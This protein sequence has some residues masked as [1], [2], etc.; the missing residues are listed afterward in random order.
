M[1][2]VTYVGNS[3]IVRRTA[4]NWRLV[5]KTISAA[6]TSFTTGASPVTLFNV[7]GDVVARVFATVQTTV[8][9]TSN[10]GTLAI[11]VT[12]NTGAF[13]AATTMDG[14]NLA[15]GTVWAGDTSPAVKS[16]AFSGTSLNG[17]PIAGGADII[18]T[19]ATNSATAG[20]LVFYCLWYP[21]SADGD[22][23]AA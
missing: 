7:T 20:V 17:A 12:G 23:Q 18:A 21:L 4:T 16:E 9:S 10:N 22:I 3:D 1:V 14:T 8:T 5:S 19:V 13:L 2:D 15:A 11:G 6:G